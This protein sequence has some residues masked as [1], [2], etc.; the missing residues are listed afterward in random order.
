MDDIE[1]FVIVNSSEDKMFKQP[2]ISQCS[3]IYSYLNNNFTKAKN[4]EKINQFYLKL[5][6][7]ITIL[8]SNKI[9]TFDDFISLYSLLNFEEGQKNLFYYI[10]NPPLNVIQTYKVEKKLIFS[11]QLLNSK[12]LEIM[13]NNLKSKDKI[14]LYCDIYEYYIIHFLLTVKN[15]SGECVKYLSIKEETVKLKINKERSFQANC[16]TSL[17][18]NYLQY[19]KNPF[20][21]KKMLFFLGFFNQ[22]CL[23]DYAQY[24]IKID[25]IMKHQQKKLYFSQAMIS[26][27]PRPKYSNLIILSLLN[28]LMPTIHDY[29]FDITTIVDNFFINLFHFFK[30][31]FEFLPNLQKNKDIYLNELGLLLYSYLIPKF[32]CNELKQR[33]KNIKNFFIQNLPFYTELINYYI[34]NYE[35]SLKNINWILMQKLLNVIEPKDNTIS[36]FQYISY[37]GL[38][39]YSTGKTKYYVGEGNIEEVVLHLH[40]NKDKLFPYSNLTNKRIVANL[41][42]VIKSNIMKKEKESIIQKNENLINILHELCAQLINLY[43]LDNLINNQKD[44]QSNS[45]KEIHL[46][47]SLKFYNKSTWELP[48]DKEEIEFLFI[49]L[50]YISYIVDKFRGIKNENGL[51]ITNLRPL[52]NYY[53]FM[54]IFMIFGMFIFLIFV[55]YSTSQSQ[56]LSKG[57][58]K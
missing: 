11:N 20:W 50:K 32:N 56:L 29:F 26:S 5:P 41:V 47:Q 15:Y 22:I 14:Y 12:L 36:I 45:K 49:L 51:P 19:L 8:F 38:R 46:S 3:Y 1:N 58:D 33:E 53:Y 30:F 24:N 52:C 10:I 37:E 17:L 35:V 44:Y 18:S 9:E 7:I 13:T 25:D 16:F 2:L 54:K 28:D 55:I 6:S 21:N 27:V 34:I 23:D 43:S 40:T 4:L 48:R 39:D 57:S 42:K 31:Q